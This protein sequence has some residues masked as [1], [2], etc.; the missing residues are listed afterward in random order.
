MS[1]EPRKRR[2]PDHPTA[3]PREPTMA[4]SIAYM[5]MLEDDAKAWLALNPSLGTLARVA[6]E[7]RIR[8]YRDALAAMRAVEAMREGLQHIAGGLA[9]EALCESS[10]HR[11]AHITGNCLRCNAR[12]TLAAAFPT[13]PARDV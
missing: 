5:S 12:A 2:Y 1:T 7:S 3:T 13:P 6:C 4:E 10:T 9:H 8:H 11:L